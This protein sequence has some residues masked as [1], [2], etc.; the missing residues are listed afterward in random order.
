MKFDFLRNT[1]KRMQEALKAAGAL[2]SRPCGEISG[3]S[4]TTLGM[5][6]NNDVYGVLPLD[7][8]AEQLQEMAKYYPCMK[9][10]FLNV[11]PHKLPAVWFSSAALFGT[12]MTR[13]IISGMSLR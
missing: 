5:T 12:L 11:H 1:P 7:Q 4:S 13:S 2:S 9:E 8:W 10:L 6:G 3:D